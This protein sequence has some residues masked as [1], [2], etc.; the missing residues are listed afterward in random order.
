MRPIAFSI[1]SLDIYW[2]GILMAS[3]FVAAY[4]IVRYLAR[5]HKLNV[6][7]IEDLFF[8]GAFTGLIGSRVAQSYPICPT[9]SPIR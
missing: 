9:T 4:C 1:G 8:V 6:S 7:V 2:Y 5:H 3:T